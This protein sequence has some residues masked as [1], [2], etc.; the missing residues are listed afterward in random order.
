MHIAVGDRLVFGESI[1]LSDDMIVSHRDVNSPQTQIS[2]SDFGTVVSINCSDDQINPIVQIKMDKG[3]VIETNWNRLIT[4]SIQHDEKSHA[5]KIQHA[6][7]CTAHASQG[8]T[9]YKSFIFDGHGGMTSEAA[10][11][12]LTRHRVDA[13]IYIDTSPVREAL[14]ARSADIAIKLSKRGNLDAPDQ[15]DC[16]SVNQKSIELADIKKSIRVVYNRS[17]MKTNISTFANDIIDWLA[18]E[19]SLGSTNVFS[20]G[21]RDITPWYYQNDGF[22][23]L[24]AA[25]RAEAQLAHKKWQALNPD[26]HTFDL[27]E[28]AK[29]RHANNIQES[30]QPDTTRAAWHPYCRLP[31]TEPLKPARLARN[32]RQRINL[33]VAH[34]VPDLQ[35]TPLPAAIEEL[36]AA[37]QAREQ[38]KLAKQNP[39]ELLLTHKPTALRVENIK[40][41]NRKRY[42]DISTLFKM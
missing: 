18:G 21:V 17:G 36:A 30:G 19:E 8:S 24:S 42:D 40:H 14:E 33:P 1:K 37:H 7:S 20:P 23:S 9:V 4:K 6:F 22:E 15:G 10:L 27:V 11:V 35:G 31:P 29:R 28:Y 38:E 39:K 3:V 5:P 12:S 2:N 26:L 25:M 34:P 13:R 16:F 32:M 41:T